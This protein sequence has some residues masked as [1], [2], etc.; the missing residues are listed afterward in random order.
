MSDLK[1]CPFCGETQLHQ[2]GSLFIDCPSCGAVGP[3][4]QDDL[5]AVQNWNTRHIDPATRAQIEADVLLKVADRLIRSPAARNF[6]IEEADRI[7]KEAAK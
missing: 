7:L 2:N 3:H 4:A 1:P 5:C 6:L